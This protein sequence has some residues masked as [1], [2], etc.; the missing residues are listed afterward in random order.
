[1]ASTDPPIR[2][3]RDDRLSDYGDIYVVSPWFQFRGLPPLPSTH[4]A[5]HTL[6]HG[7][8]VA[9]VVE[10][11]VARLFQLCLSIADTLGENGLSPFAYALAF[12]TLNI[13][14]PIEDGAFYLEL[15]LET[16]A[17]SHLSVVLLYLYH[18]RQFSEPNTADHDDQLVR[19]VRAWARRCLA[20]LDG[21]ELVLSW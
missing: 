11:R 18:R 13:N 19:L 7:S 16:Y 20:G 3:R 12:A 5:F 21:W 1:M 15:L 6:I 2:G 8:D 9:E 10:V 4:H 14:M 17:A